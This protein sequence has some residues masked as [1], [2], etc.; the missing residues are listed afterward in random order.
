MKPW[1]EES[2]LFNASHKWFKNGSVSVTVKGSTLSTPLPNVS[3]LNSRKVVIS[4][5]N[6]SSNGKTEEMLVQLKDRNKKLLSE[7]TVK[8]NVKS[9]KKH[10][11]RTF[12]SQIDGSVQYYSV[13]PSNNDTL[14]KPA[15]FLSVHGAS[16]EATNQANAYKQKDWGHLVAPTNRRPFGF[17]W[18]DWGRLDALEVLNEAEKRFKPINNVLI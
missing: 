2:E 5:P 9:N 15:L 7:Y 8:L 16:V 17:A 3:P 12:V 11:K 18:E 14:T 1:L 4:I 13:A 6:V 10:H